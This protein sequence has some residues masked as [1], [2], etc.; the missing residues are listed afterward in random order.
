M[1]V[2]WLLG[3]S[4]SALTI[5][6]HYEVLHVLSVSIGRLIQNHRRRTVLAVLILF[7]AHVAE[8]WLFAGGHYMAVEWF[9]LGQLKGEFS[10]AIRDYAY[11]SAITYTTVGY[12]DI[13]PIGEVRIIAGLESLTGLMMIAWS[14][15]FTV[16]N[17]ERW[18]TKDTENNPDR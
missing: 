16:F 17:L 7:L 4:L 15:A 12:G 11:F 5:A 3:L 1:F 14:A 13:Y 6:F 18:W 10:G 2:A 8:I 9:S